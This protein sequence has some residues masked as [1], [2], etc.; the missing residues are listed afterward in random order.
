MGPK[1]SA[2]D[3]GKRPI[4]KTKKI[5]L[6][7]PQN[8]KMNSTTKAENRKKKKKMKD[9]VARKRAERARKADKK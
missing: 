5:N 6:E 2:A 9:T 7:A 8:C 3:C 1:K 4:R